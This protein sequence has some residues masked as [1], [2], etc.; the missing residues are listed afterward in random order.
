M[1][2]RKS[3]DEENDL[4]PGVK[5]EEALADAL[6]EEAAGVAAT[7]R[8]NTS[9]AP[10]SSAKGSKRCNLCE[11]VPS[12]QTP[13]TGGPLL[14]KWGEKIPW[15]AGTPDN[16]VGNYDLPCVRA[17]NAGAFALEHGNIS[18]YQVAISKKHKS[19]S[20]SWQPEPSGSNCTTSIQRAV[21]ERHRY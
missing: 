19:T 4:Q 20:G 6:A 21:F 13:L 7:P 15:A 17:F 5:E 11:A 9:R 3:D 14:V 10:S 8:S 2:K 16:P 12:D 1:P 18:A